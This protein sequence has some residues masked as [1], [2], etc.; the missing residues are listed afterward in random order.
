MGEKKQP[1]FASWF[2]SPYYPILYQNRDEAEAEAFL[3]RIT[4]HLELPQGARLL[5][6]A[7][8]RGRHSVVLNKLGF[9]VLGVDLSPHSIADAK[10][11]QAPGLSFQVHD[12]RE[13]V[14]PEGFDAVLSLFTSFGY[15]PTRADD[16]KTLAAMAANLRPGGRLLL[17]FLNA[18][19]VISELV[20]HAEKDIEG[21]HFDLKKSVDGDQ[22]VK[23]IYIQDGDQTHHFEE[24][25]RAWTRAEFE[26][27]LGQV[28]LSVQEVFGDYQLGAY[29]PASSPRLTLLAQKAR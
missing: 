28:G 22:I 14:E 5:D 13:V 25:V 9:E 26:A 2:D 16:E 29:D 21:I 4:S 23:R 10:A 7:C 15:L 18:P 27:A 1:W 24:R 11:H 19:K 6:L 12:M 8:G 3:S 20:P 17:D